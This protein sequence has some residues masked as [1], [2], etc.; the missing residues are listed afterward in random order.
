MINYNEYY[1]MLNMF[2]LF[3]GY[4]YTDDYHFGTKNVHLDFYN[5]P[6]YH[7]FECDLDLTKTFN[8]VCEDLLLAFD[9]RFEN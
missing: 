9:K 8:E 7:G 5:A 2:T 3:S 1:L 4:E 6:L